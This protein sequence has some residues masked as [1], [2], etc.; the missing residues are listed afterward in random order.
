MNKLFRDTIRD[1]RRETIRSHLNGIEN[2]SFE[3]AVDGLRDRMGY[4]T[5]PE[6][7][8]IKQLIERKK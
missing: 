5:P 3:D 4:I 8:F 2:I 6:E 7:N 1:M